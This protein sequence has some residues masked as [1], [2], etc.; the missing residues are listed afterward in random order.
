MDIQQMLER[1]LTGQ[2][3]MLEKMEADRKATEK[4]C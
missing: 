1:L 3:R 4:K 2:E